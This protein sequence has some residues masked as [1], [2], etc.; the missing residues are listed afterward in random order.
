MIFNR[1]HFKPGAAQFDV[2]LLNP[3]EALG[4]MPP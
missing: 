2:D 1:R 3:A 4:K